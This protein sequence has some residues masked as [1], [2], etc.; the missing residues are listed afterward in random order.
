M[1]KLQSLRQHPDGDT[2][3]PTAQPTM[4]Q[5]PLSA[6]PATQATRAPT[7]PVPTQAATQAVMPNYGASSAD[8]EQERMAWMNAWK[9]GFAQA[10]QQAQ[11]VA[12]EQAR[13]QADA[14]LMAQS[15]AT[16]KAKAEQEAADRKAGDELMP[17]AFL[18]IKAT[19]GPRRR[20]ADLSVDDVANLV[21]GVGLGQYASRLEAN[22]VD[23]AALAEVE[24]PQEL[25]EVGV[26]LTLQQKKMVR[27]CKSLRAG[28]VPQSLLDEGAK[29]R[30]SEEH[31][32]DER[33]RNEPVRGVGYRK[34]E[35]YENGGRWGATDTATDTAAADA[36]SG[37]E[38]GAADDAATTAETKA[39]GKEGAAAPSQQPWMDGAGVAWYPAAGGGFV[40]GPPPPGPNIAANGAAPP[41]MGVG[42]VVPPAPPAAGAIPGAGAASTGPNDATPMAPQGMSPQGMIPPG[43]VPHPSANMA[44]MMGMMGMAPN[45]MR[46][47]SL[48][49]G[50][51]LRLGRGRGRTGTTGRASAWVDASN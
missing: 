3:A 26:D 39:G 1:S 37:Q 41:M 11:Q 34:G 33:Q 19:E 18:G 47:V 24:A 17:A 38:K 42:S 22:C 12:N 13:V 20:L 25:A 23:G 7:L 27:L 44:G 29:R 15:Q 21:C 10:Q 4:R 36:A 48:G 49:S 9:E 45:N 51:G 43:M 35:R 28:G 32:E 30:Q 16:A 31:A 2:P 5:A 6:A 14:L 8:L 40:P 46:F 50:S